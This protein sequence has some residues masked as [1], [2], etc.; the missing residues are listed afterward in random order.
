MTSPAAQA[1]PGVEIGPV[2][3]WLAA[4]L[5][6]SVPPYEFERVVGGHSNLTYIVTDR[7]DQQWVLRRPPL[8]ELLPTAHDMGR[9]FR[10]LSALG[11]C[12]PVPRVVGLCRDE[13]ITGAPFYVME[14][15]DGLVV[16]DEATA[17]SAFDAAGRQRLGYDLADVLA[18]IHSVSPDEVGLGDLGRP[19][20]YVARQLRR[21]KRQLDQSKTRELPQLDRLLGQLWDHLP[22]Q[23]STRLVHGDYRLDNCIASPDGSVRAVLDWELCT[24]GEPLADLGLLMVYWSEPGDDLRATQDAPTAVPGFPSR[25]Q[26]LERYAQTLGRD[27][28]A[29]DFYVAFSYWRLACITEGVLARY[30]AGGMGNRVSEAR[31]FSERVMTL[32]EGAERITRLW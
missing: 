22:A 30:L 2:S 16:R 3:A 6:A 24:V 4:Q 8:G 29:I 10:L 19:G 26:M 18:A 23:T 28:P 11:P 27:L 13:S 5:P 31:H 7:R 12:L 15:V 1:P 25:S 21:W 14:K 17:A 32:I 20:D 9:E